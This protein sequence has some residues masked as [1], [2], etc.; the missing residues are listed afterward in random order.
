M[1]TIPS[2]Q[3]SCTDLCHYS[4]I[5]AK[6]SYCL[7]RPE[8]SAEISADILLTRNVMPFGMVQS[9]EVENLLAQHSQCFPN[10][11]ILN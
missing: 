2:L 11:N 10:I 1:F 8:E 5:S 4:M 3:L 6:L 7:I 9:T